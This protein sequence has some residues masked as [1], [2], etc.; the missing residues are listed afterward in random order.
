[1]TTLK[2]FILLITL[3]LLVYNI[4]SFAQTELPPADNLNSLL[5]LN[6]NDQNGASINRIDA[7]RSILY[8]HEFSKTPIQPKSLHWTNYQKSKLLTFATV[9]QDRSVDLKLS[10]INTSPQFN[11]KTVSLPESL[12]E[13]Y[14]FTSWIAKTPNQLFATAK[15][16]VYLVTIGNPSQNRAI[17]IH[18]FPGQDSGIAADLTLDTTGSNL[19]FSYNTA[20]KVNKIY[21]SYNLIKKS[22]TSLNVINACKGSVKNIN[23][24]IMPMGEN[25]FLVFCEANNSAMRSAFILLDFNKKTITR[26]EVK[27]DFDTNRSFTIDRDGNYVQ[28]QSDRRRAV[29]CNGNIKLIQSFRCV[30]TFSMDK[31]YIL[32]G[33]VS[34]QFFIIN[35]KNVFFLEYLS[36]ATKKMSIN[37]NKPLTGGIISP[38]TL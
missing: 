18:K 10:V 31:G 30:N 32:A 12:K 24:R 1:M 28:I 14:A 5:F 22:I 26:Y 8:T 4:K 29:Y 9:N 33:N 21:F 16:Q 38:V 2:N 27:N 20:A 36:G 23:D 13:D 7:R 11:I 15:D 34:S 37:F 25:T 17:V 3:A 6:A 19:A 35:D